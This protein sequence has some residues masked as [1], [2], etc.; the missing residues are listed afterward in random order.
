MEGHDK[1]EKI[2]FARI[3]RVK[4]LLR[5]M[6]RKATVHNYPFL[7]FF[8]ASVKKRHYLWSFRVAE[9][10]PALYAG[11]ILTF[12]PLYGV[13]I[14]VALGL[15]LIFRA[16]LMVLVGLQLISNPLTIVPIYALDYQVGHF[17]IEFFGSG[18]S[19]S[20]TEEIQA[21]A[22]ETGKVVSQSKELIKGALRG[23]KEMMLGGAIIGYVFGFISSII[24][25]VAAKRFSKNKPKMTPK[26]K[27]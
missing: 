24:Y 2:R 19:F 10:V 23:F 9:V 8:A 22:E 6:P 4:K 5:Y 7:K 13:Q 25:R 27:A 21:Y 1:E 16:N 17:F 12:T 20:G 26:K 18:S 14:P 15:A 3:R 11:S